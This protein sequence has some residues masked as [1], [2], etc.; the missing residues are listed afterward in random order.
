[1]KLFD[2]IRIWSRA[3]GRGIFPHQMAWVLDLPGRWI[4]M[5]ANTVAERL[6]VKPNARILEIGPGSGYYSVQVAKRIPNGH[7]TL[8]DIQYEMLEK[9]ANKLKAAGITNFSTKQS[10]GKS[11]PFADGS[12]DL[13]FMV[14]V[15]GE[16]EERES[17]LFEASRVLKANGVLSITEHHPDP[18]F[19]HAN[20][21]AE[22]L[23]KH[24]FVP[25]Q[26]LGW[27]WAY[28]LNASKHCDIEEM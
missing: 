1:M 23:Y 15:F 25:T 5:S 13:I 7:L 22:C 18:D 17:F 24:G 4:I 20:V 6:P 16:I 28:T 10:D 27:R 2:Q 26:Q 12:F 14:T 8:L 21:I 11:L 19:E 3:F 9:S